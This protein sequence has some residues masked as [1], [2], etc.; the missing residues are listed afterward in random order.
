MIPE[1][2]LSRWGE[3]IDRLEIIFLADN[4]GGYP[5]ALTFHVKTADE[6]LASLR[7]MGFRIKE[8]YEMPIDILKPSTQDNLARWVRLTNGIAVSLTDGFVCR[9]S[10]EAKKGGTGRE[11]GNACIL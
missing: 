10:R 7:V 2:L 6:R 3:E 1:N 5:D 11:K 9:S 4:G 8:Q